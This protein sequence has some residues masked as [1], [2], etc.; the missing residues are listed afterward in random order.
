SG[1]FENL[2]RFDDN[3]G[4]GV[5][6]PNHELTVNGSVS[7]SGGEIGARI[8]IFGDTITFHLLAMREGSCYGNN[9]GPAFLGMGSLRIGQSSDLFNFGSNYGAGDPVANGMNVVGNLSVA[10]SLVV[11]QIT[12]INQ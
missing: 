8:G 3:I 2:E 9:F 11:Q 12:N 7:V 6:N 4:I 5:A 10:D 1:T